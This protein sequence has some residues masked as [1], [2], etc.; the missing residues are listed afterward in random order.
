M[1]Y[2]ALCL[3][4]PFLATPAWSQDAP[5]MAAEE[6]EREVGGFQTPSGLEVGFGAEVRTYVDG[7]LALQ[8]HLTWTDQGAVQ[9]TAAANGSTDLSDAAGGGIHIFGAPGTGLYLPGDNGGTVVLH[10]LDSDQISGLIFNTADNR[11]IRQEVN[12][13]LN[14][15]DLTQFQKDVAGQQLDLRLQETIGRAL[16]NT[17]R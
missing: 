11:D 8:T 16:E 7:Q 1:K 9:T 10:G 15:P 6:L 13:M 3:M 4:I 2:A 17:L 14:V 12:V 5:P